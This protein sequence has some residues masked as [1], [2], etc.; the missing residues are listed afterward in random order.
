MH[1]NFQH[2]DVVKCAYRHVHTI[3]MFMGQFDPFRQLF[4]YRHKI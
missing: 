1:A 4:K 3:L 2:S